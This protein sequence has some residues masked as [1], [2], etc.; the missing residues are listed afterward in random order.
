VINI[1]RSFIK[2]IVEVELPDYVK[3]I[4]VFELFEEISEVSRSSRYV[5]ERFSKF[6]VILVYPKLIDSWTFPFKAI[7]SS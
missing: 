3:K 1:I 2:I 6:D 7:L 4:M 5:F